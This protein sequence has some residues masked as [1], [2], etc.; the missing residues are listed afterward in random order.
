MECDHLDSYW[1]RGPWLWDEALWHWQASRG[2]LTHQAPQPAQAQKPET[3]RVAWRRHKGPQQGPRLRHIH[4]LGWW[5]HLQG[6][7]PT[8]PP[9]GGHG[10]GQPEA[11][12]PVGRRH[13]GVLPLP[14]PT[15]ETFETLFTPPAQPIP[16]RVAALGCQVG[17]QKPWIGVTHVPP[18]HQRT[19]QT[20]LRRHERG[21]APAPTLANAPHQLTQP[22][23][24]R[25]ARR[26][27][28]GAL[29]DAQQRMP[30][31]AD[32]PQKEPARPQPPVG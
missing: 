8:H 12:R 32:N 2:D 20:P 5:S 18:G 21:P 9:Q 11:C 7:A 10:H 23:P 30:A 28:L 17:Q 15:L 14:A 29:V 24:A 22:I 19:R 3:A 16:R 6:T 31:Q 25:L 4:T 13:L 1:Y 27:Q 26:A